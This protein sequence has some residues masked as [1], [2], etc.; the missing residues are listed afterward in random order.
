MKESEGQRVR[1]ELLDSYRWLIGN[2]P[3]ADETAIP[4]TVVIALLDELAVQRQT[5]S[6]LVAGCTSERD[7]VDLVREGLRKGERLGLGR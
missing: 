7:L 5:I 3:G 4:I 6:E 1:R 2:R